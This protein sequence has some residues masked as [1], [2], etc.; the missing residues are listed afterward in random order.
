MHYVI[1][2]VHGCYDLFLKMLDKINFS[3]DDTLYLLG[4]MID[5]EP[6]GIRLMQDVM[7]RKNV[8][9]FLGNHEDMLYRVIRS[10]GKKLTKA[11][12]LEVEETLI[13]WVEYNGGDVTWDA[14]R[15]LSEA[16]RKELLDYLETFSVYEELTVGENEYLLVHAGIGKYAPDKD[17]ADCTLHE[18][19]W[20]RMDYDKSY[21]PDTYIVSGHTPT[22]LI[23]PNYIGRIYRKNNHI[24]VDCGAAFTGTLGC[25]C[26][27]TLEE[28]YVNV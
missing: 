12:R 20:E 8:V 18:L 16:E 28:I 25:L 10:I 6:D 1:S 5:R 19:I 26:L 27:E 24:A 14:W 21:F 22:V 17:P 23:D 3:E 2:D 13:C 4:D 15:A 7:R 9:P 11:E